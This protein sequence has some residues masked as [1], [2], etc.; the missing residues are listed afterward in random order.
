MRLLCAAKEDLFALFGTNVRNVWI[1]S[2]WISTDGVDLL[3]QAI[4]RMGPR[5]LSVVDV[6]VRLNLQDRWA[7]LT[8]YFALDKLAEWLRKEGPGVRVT[9][10]TSASL[11]AKIVWTERGAL[12][13]SANLTRAGYESNVEASV[14]L[15]P[16][17]CA[18]QAAFRETL[19]ARME[20]VRDER[21]REFVQE[22][23][24]PETGPVPGEAV[25]PGS[26]EGW[27]EFL[28]ALLSEKPPHLRGLR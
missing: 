15:G 13:G 5:G 17:E 26:G 11:H 6:W 4:E 7:G 14:R 3:R 16:E 22:T 12:I 23:G 21:W 19:Q 20:I 18:A 27:Q 25:P 24:Q 9:F 1:S 2:P 28:G 8:D 10:W